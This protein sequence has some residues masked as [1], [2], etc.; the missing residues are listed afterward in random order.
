MRNQAKLVTYG[1]YKD[2]CWWIYVLTGR[3]FFQNQ[4][5]DVAATQTLTRRD[6]GVPGVVAQRRAAAR[7]GA[8]ADESVAAVAGP[9]HHAVDVAARLR[10][11]GA[12]ERRV[13]RGAVERWRMGGKQEVSRRGGKKRQKANFSK[14]FLDIDKLMQRCC[15][16]YVHIYFP[17]V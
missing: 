13:R 9:A 4:T 15:N 8:V 6:T 5:A 11:D 3:L 16:T 12:V 17:S 10:G 1:T 2:L 7:G 14:T